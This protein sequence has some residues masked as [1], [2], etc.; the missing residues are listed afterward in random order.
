MT[1]LG[2]ASLAFLL[3]FRPPSHP[4]CSRNGVSSLAPAGNNPAAE[5][6][7]G[8][9][10]L[11]PDHSIMK[12]TKARRQKSA[13]V[14][15]LVADGFEQV[16]LTGPRSALDREGFVTHVVSPNRF[17]GAMKEVTATA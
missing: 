6:T 13:N 12:P 1:D 16:E 15:I 14:A 7:I 17:M 11:V 4:K 5:A 3:A 9:I 2:P 10:G 8:S